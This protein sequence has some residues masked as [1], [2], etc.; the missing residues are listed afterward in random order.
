[1]MKKKSILLFSIM[2]LLTSCYKASINGDLDGMWQLME[3]AKSSGERLDTKN[4]RLYYSVQL[5][6]ISLRKAG[7]GQYL[8]R[9]VYSGD[10]LLVNDFRIYRNEDI[11]AKETD[12]LPFGLSG[13]SEH[14]KVE[15]LGQKRMVLKSAYATLHFRRY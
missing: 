1:M 11:P 2:I 15:E 12:L 7:G 9:F 14:F 3:I 6:L 8:G 5:H 13:L 4:D 10:S